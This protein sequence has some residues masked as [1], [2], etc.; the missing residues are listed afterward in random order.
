ML[1]KVT[2]S[3]TLGIKMADTPNNGESRLDR[4]ERGIEHM[5][6]LSASHEANFARH[7]QEIA[8]LRE[9][10]NRTLTMLEGVLQ[11]SSRHEEEISN[12]NRKVAEAAEAARLAV[13]A[14]K[15]TDE[16]L[17]ALIGFVAGWKSHPPQPPKQ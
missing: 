10:A 14:G 8:S 13:E 3:C 15:N 17:N 16:R 5:L 1:C 9:I 4:I 7:D 2:D 11:V 12:M 6:Q